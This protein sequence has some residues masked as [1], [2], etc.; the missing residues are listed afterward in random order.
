MP[1]RRTPPAPTA[2]DVVGLFMTRQN[3]GNEARLRRLAETF[4]S[5]CRLEHPIAIPEA[6]RATA[7]EVR[8]PYVR[9]AWT[10]IT[11]ALTQNAWQ[12]HFDPKVEGSDKSKRAAGVAE[13]WCKAG[14]TQM[15]KA[16]GFDVPQEACAQ[17]VRDCESVIQ[18]VHRPDAWATF[19]ARTLGDDPT[20]YLDKAETYKKG[21][22]FPFAWR[23]LDRLAYLPGEGEFGD[24][25][26][27]TYG[28]YARSYLASRYRMRADERTGRLTAAGA[29]EAGRAVRP[30][31]FEGRPAPQGYF[32]GTTGMGVK[33]EYFDPWHW[34]VVVDGAM[35]PGWPRDNPYGPYLP[36]VRA[37]P[38]EEA[39]SVL[40]S[41]L[42]L[43]PRLDE[44][45]TMWLNW[46][47][48]G[49]FPTPLLQDLPGTTAIP[50]GM[51]P[52]LGTE[53][54]PALYQWTPGRM[55]EVPTGKSLGFL[56]APPVGGDLKEMAQVL[57]ALI[58]VAGIPSIM[59][60][61]N[62]SGDSGYLAN[63]M[64]SAVLMQY[65][66]LQRA[67]ERQ[68][69]QVHEI[70]LHFC[71]HRIKTTVYVLGQAAG[72]EGGRYL[73][74][75]PSG[76]TT[77][78]LAGIDQLGPVSV[79]APPD[80]SVMRQAMAMIAKQVTAGPA[81]QRLYSRR[82]A[83]ETLMGEEDPD[84]II[85]EIWV[86]DQ[87]A[88]NPAVNQVVVSNAIQ[89]SGLL[90]VPREPPPGPPGTPGVGPP[91]VPGLP[92]Q[93]AGGVPVLPG[94]GMPLQPPPPNGPTGLVG[95]GGRPP[96]MYPGQPP[97]PPNAPMGGP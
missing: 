49:A 75:R 58:E 89:R 16:V 77:P 91:G 64:I 97:S 80:M 26:C 41:L 17:M 66:N 79:S 95:Q 6:Y 21:A 87:M 5:L 51:L 36:Y 72:E 81:D 83:L 88:T 25:Y 39:D 22:P 40:Y 76:D 90:P 45:L 7:R 43:A 50:P 57:R 4:R 84:S 44:L 68:L 96:G 60:G 30:E 74:L 46:T 56:Q 42:F 38:S 9:D 61:S 55:Q 10:R 82:A 29:D 15:D 93:V 62:L 2:G 37:K 52:P 70:V 11:A 92:G 71:V 28:E 33:L 23:P 94:L 35:A 67:R 24:D 54:A 85:D 73:G 18:V 78:N 59:R 86:E 12:P 27:V 48:L 1:D 47:H 8:T 19:P 65:K 3:D 13:R 14:T 31:D 34:C 32:S 69:E 20:A 63:Q 53:T